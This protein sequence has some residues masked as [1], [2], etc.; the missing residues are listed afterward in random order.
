MESNYQR[1]SEFFKL[2]KELNDEERKRLLSKIGNLKT[3]SK[4]NEV[5]SEKVQEEKKSQIVYANT[6]YQSGGILYRIIIMII[7]LF[8]G[9]KKEDVIIDNELNNIK[10]YLRLNYSSLIDFKENRLTHNFIKEI[11]QLAKLAY[12][13]KEIVNKYFG[14]DF[15]FTSFLSVIAEEMFS[16]KIKT[17]LF[18]LHPET[19]ANPQE[20]SDKTNFFQEKEKRLKKFMI[21]LDVVIFENINLQINKFDII[22]KLINFDYKDLL[23]SFLLLDVN[24]QPKSANFCKFEQIDLSLQRLYK[25]LYSINFSVSDIIFLNDMLEYCQINPINYPKEAQYNE[26]T[27]KD[28]DK[29]IEYAKLLKE[30]IPFKEI[31]QYFYKDIL[32][33]I[34]P[35][36]PN[37]NFTDVYKEYKKTIVDKLWSQHYVELRKKNLDLFINNLMNGYDFN[38]FSNFNKNLKLELERHSPNKIVNFYTLSIFYE[39]LVSIYKIKIEI[40]IN[41]ILIEGIFKKDNVRANLFVSYYTLNGFPEKLR[42][43]DQKLNPEKDYGKKIQ[44]TIKRVIADPSFKTP[45]IGIIN[46]INDES[47]KLKQEIADSFKTVFNFISS[48]VDAP[49]PAANPLT[50]FDKIKIPGHPNSFIAVE[51]SVEL[52]KKFYQIYNLIEEIY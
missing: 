21:Q 1:P 5:S 32:Y 44:N 40:I 49:E 14:D 48:L 42:E 20:L 39:F 19:I 41:K 35:I 27:I 15:Y 16:D 30:K 26:E 3:D 7:S 37:L 33:K 2:S 45:I 10:K 52:F 34:K 29:L 8:S 36:R 24:E 12:K 47:Y 13:I 38:S 22:N 43:F 17:N 6:V 50:N 11:Q 9:R 4:E 31:F 51:K 18:E 23:S 28:F 46:E 25:L